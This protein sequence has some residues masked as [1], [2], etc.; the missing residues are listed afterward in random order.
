MNCRSDTFDLIIQY[1]DILNNLVI[2][3]D[4]LD[5]YLCGNEN[6]KFYCYILHNC[7]IDEFGIKKTRHYHVV[8]RIENQLSKNTIINDIAKY[9]QCNKNII[10]CRCC[11][12]NDICK[13]VRYLTHEF[14]D[15]SKHKHV[16]MRY[17]VVRSDDEIYNNI[18]TYNSCC[19]IVSVDYLV[20]LCMSSK[21]ILEVYS[22]LGLKDSKNYRF[23]I[24]DIWKYCAESK[25]RKEIKK[26]LGINNEYV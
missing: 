19:F 14:E 23:I 1:E 9:F 25:E 15:L 21:N 20:T 8:I 7:D 18:M 10:S 12:G 5:K 26:R 17:E 2:S 3:C 22:K 13:A 4:L 11:F 16:Y 6:I 24:A